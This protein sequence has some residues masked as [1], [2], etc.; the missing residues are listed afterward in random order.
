MPFSDI[1]QQS[2]FG[3]LL[4]YPIKLLK[5]LWH[6]VV[7][8]VLLPI[9]LAQ[10]I[11]H[12]IL[13]F[14]HWILPD[15]FA[16]NVYHTFRLLGVLFVILLIASL[17]CVAI[18]GGIHVLITG[19]TSLILDVDAAQ[20]IFIA[21]KTI[22]ATFGIFVALAVGGFLVANLL[23][24]FGIA[25]Y[26]TTKTAAEIPERFK[27]KAVRMMFLA[28]FLVAVAMFGIVYLMVSGKLSL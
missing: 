22:L 23:S 26:S 14:L 3:S 12:G 2:A 4:K 9:H 5:L 1:S 24:A 6:L 18:I 28:I 20:A 17:V 16:E 7:A 27:Y 11:F 10:K 25:A 21:V 8:A 13:T 15:I 19:G